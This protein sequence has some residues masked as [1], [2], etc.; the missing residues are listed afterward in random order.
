MNFISPNASV[1][2]SSRILISTCNG[3]PIVVIV[4]AVINIELFYYQF[5]AVLHVSE[6]KPP[7]NGWEEFTSTFKDVRLGGAYGAVDCSPNLLVHETVRW[8]L[9]A[10]LSRNLQCFPDAQLQ[11]H[12]R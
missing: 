4:V 3:H 1:F 2:R 12:A 11:R 9:C 10:W 6:V 7:V 5:R 8:H